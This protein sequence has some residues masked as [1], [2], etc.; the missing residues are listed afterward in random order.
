MQDKLNLNKASHPDFHIADLHSLAEINAEVNTDTYNFIFIDSLNVLH[1]DTE[2]M[3]ELRK[4]YQGAAM[5]TVSQSTKDGKIRGSQEIVHDCD[6]AIDVTNGIAR[7][8]KNR[9][10]TT[11]RE[12][13]IFKRP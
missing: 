5:I 2:A 4:R 9:F 1:I 10:Q 11:P 8:T 12:L 13:A 6:V 7:T 3:R